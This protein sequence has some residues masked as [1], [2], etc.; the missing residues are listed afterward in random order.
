M[1]SF[2]IFYVSKNNMKEITVA[3]ILV[4]DSNKCL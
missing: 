1:I 4:N 2:D 3:K